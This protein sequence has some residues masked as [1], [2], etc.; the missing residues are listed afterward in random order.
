[1][2]HAGKSEASSD[3]SPPSTSAWLIVNALHAEPHA[4]LP[5]PPVAVQ[6]GD[7]ASP[8]AGLAPVRAWLPDRKAGHHFT[9]ASTAT[10]INTGAA[11]S[12]TAAGC[13]QVT[14]R[15]RVRGAPR[16][17]HSLAV[18]RTDQPRSRGI[19]REN[20]V[21][22]CCRRGSTHLRSKRKHSR[23]GR[24]FVEAQLPFHHAWLDGTSSV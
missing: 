10:T 4:R 9:P 20:E 8:H 14:V 2:R 15:P 3:A 16:P 23:G 18:H 7:V 22:R 11:Q 19:L 12:R 24:R 17:R 6:V 5:V 1:M 13:A 21:G